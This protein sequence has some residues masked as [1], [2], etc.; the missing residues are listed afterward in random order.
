MPLGKKT[1]PAKFIGAVSLGLG[2][3][4][5]ATSIIGGVQEKKRLREENQIAKKQY[6]G[7]RDDINALEITNPYKDLNTN[8]DKELLEVVV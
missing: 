1:S 7:F 2:V 8:F 5:G 6:R 3:I 4:K